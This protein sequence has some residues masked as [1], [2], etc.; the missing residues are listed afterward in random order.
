MAEKSFKQQIR[1]S[2][3]AVNEK[4]AST[5]DAQTA[6][7][8]TQAFIASATG[9]NFGDPPEAAEAHDESAP[10]AAETAHL[11]ASSPEAVASKPS[12]PSSPIAAIAQS[13]PEEEWE[14]AEWED[15][16]VGRKFA[17]KAKK[18]EKDQIYKHMQMRADYDRQKA[19][20][21]RFQNE[22]QEAIESGY[23]DR[24]APVYK[25]IDTDPE[26]ARAVS[27][28]YQQRMQ[29]QPLNYS[30][31]GYQPPEQVQPQPQYQP[32]PQDQVFSDDPYLQAATQPLVGRLDSMDQ[33]TQQMY[34]WM[35]TQQHQAQQ[36]Q[37]AQQARVAAEN[38]LRRS[39][40]YLAQ[41]F[42]QDFTGNIAQDFPKLQR[43][44]Q[45]A[46]QAGYAN[47]PVYGTYG[48]MLQAKIA[49]DASAPRG[50]TQAVP[51]AAAQTI[52]AVEAQTREASR[53]A[54]QEVANGT[55]VS[56]GQAPDPKPPRPLPRHKKDGT[57]IPVRSF[58]KNAVERLM[59]QTE[60]Q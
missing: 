16:S 20:L 33:R 32:Q 57:P 42:P 54:S 25:A 46:D 4:I 5:D 26:L 52:A 23:M 38:D 14:D 7:P 24:V 13:E 59:N 40:M 43:L 17:F 1:D 21:G 49:L 6:S 41:N 36:Q 50:V 44:V 27:Q 56:V 39:H 11:E 35:Q 19:R 31:P 15:S 12:E 37:Q 18:G 30:Q 45:Y 34:D 58:V 60:Q 2:V 51:S 53:K 10:E 8:D 47:D 55:V 48:R 28:L 29:N 3:K 22:F 9:P